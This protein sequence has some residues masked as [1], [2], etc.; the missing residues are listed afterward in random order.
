MELR[1]KTEE[2]HHDTA[3]R[4]HGFYAE[5]CPVYRSLKAAIEITTSLT[6]EARV[7]GPSGAPR[8]SR[9]RVISVA[10]VAC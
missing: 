5:K 4:V 2:R 9:N 10:S 6:F 8:G 7:V 3:N 1:L